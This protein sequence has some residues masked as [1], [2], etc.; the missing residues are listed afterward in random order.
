MLNAEWGEPARMRSVGRAGT[1]R[2]ARGPARIVGRRIRAQIAAFAFLR[3]KRRGVRAPG[4]GRRRE[5]QKGGAL[6]EPWDSS[7]FHGRRDRNSDESNPSANA[8][9]VEV[10]P[11]LPVLPVPVANGQ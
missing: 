8:P 1:M 11:M 2:G 9:G 7:E 3:R 6:A 4:A 10:L 5:T